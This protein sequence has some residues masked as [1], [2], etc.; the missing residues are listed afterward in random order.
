ME[1]L[2]IL[3]VA[4]AVDLFLGEYPP[5]LH[6]VVWMGRLTD[7]LVDRSPKS[8]PT[9]Q[10]LYGVLMVLA[11]LALF[12]G[13][14][15]F[16]TAFFQRTGGIVYVLTGA[17]LLKSAFS[18]RAL[19]ASVEQVRLEL[20]Y[21]D[22]QEARRALGR[23]VSRDVA[24]L[25]PSL[26]AAAA[27]ESAAENYIDSFVAPLLYF[28]LLGPVGAIA[29]RVVNTMDAM[30]GYR[31]R[32]EYLGKAAARLDDVLN[33]VPAR[34]AALLLAVSAGPVGGSPLGALRAMGR[35]HGKTES[36]N[37][38]WTMSAMAGALGVEL[39]KPG[40]YRLG[41]GNREPENSDVRR[42]L[43]VLAAAAALALLL[44][45]LAEAV[46]HVRAT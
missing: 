6:P 2:A 41:A 4:L 8:G 32:Y 22:L 15:W 23:I 42:S 34:L 29:Y 10:L 7:A 16:L 3:G 5:R 35:E 30:V 11:A 18:L 40:V 12:V 39:V 27:I 26:V 33:Y 44:L 37:A 20:T 46:L 19:W 13:P 28:L 36:P 31:G 21:G 1:E 9:R 17:V 24:T 43:L 14:A 45:V 25:S 38:G